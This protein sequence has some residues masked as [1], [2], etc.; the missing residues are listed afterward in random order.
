MEPPGGV[1]VEA[2]QHGAPFTVAGAAAGRLLP[3]PT[4]EAV[5]PDPAAVLATTKVAREALAPHL[6]PVREVLGDLGRGF[7]E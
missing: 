5:L 2:G 1:E 4:A 3:V 7:V 6:A